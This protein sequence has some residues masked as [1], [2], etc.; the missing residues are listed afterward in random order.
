[1]GLKK[2]G[3]LARFY[4]LAGKWRR[5]PHSHD[6]KSSHQDLLTPKKRDHVLQED[7]EIKKKKTKYSINIQNYI[8]LF[9]FFQNKKKET[10]L[11][12]VQLFFYEKEFH[13]ILSFTP[14]IYTLK[15]SWKYLNILKHI[16]CHFVFKRISYIDL[17]YIFI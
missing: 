7:L 2:F 12:F 5:L 4:A 14:N 9:S 1:M 17:K 3:A 8:L 15:T 13:T 11:G 16:N 10:S 6:P